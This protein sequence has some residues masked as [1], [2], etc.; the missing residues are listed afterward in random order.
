MLEYV[1]L[2]HKQQLVCE[3]HAQGKS[4]R[5]IARIMGIGRGRVYRHLKIAKDK[6]AGLRP[7][8]F[9]FIP[10]SFDRMQIERIDGQYHQ[11]GSSARN[12]AERSLIHGGS[13]N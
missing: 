11:I 3:L 5:R 6:L 13:Y 2:T 1:K 9:R 10:Q 8:I 12:S 4:E 7:R